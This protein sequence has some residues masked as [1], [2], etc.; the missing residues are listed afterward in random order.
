MHFVFYLLSGYIALFQT[1]PAECLLIETFAMC[2]QPRCYLRL[3]IEHFSD[4][5][6]A[7]SKYYSYKLF[8][9]SA[10]SVLILTSKQPVLL[11]HLLFTH[12]LVHCN[13]LAYMLYNQANFQKKLSSTNPKPYNFRSLVPLDS[14]G[15][16]SY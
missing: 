1:I 10:V 3:F 15:M 4:Q 16:I 12:K 7:L 5:R 6:S 8:T 2:S 14:T 13:S 11:S 9:N